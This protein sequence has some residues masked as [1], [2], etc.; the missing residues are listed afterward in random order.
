M[1]RIQNLQFAYANGWIEESVV[2]LGKTGKKHILVVK[3]HNRVMGNEVAG[4][5][6][7]KGM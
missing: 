4:P 1:C 2:A 5:K 3:E 6:A 7:E